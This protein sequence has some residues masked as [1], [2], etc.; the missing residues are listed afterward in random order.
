MKFSGV[1]IQ[2][3]AKVGVE[4]VRRCRRQRVESILNHRTL[5]V[6][7]EKILSKDSCGA[8]EANVSE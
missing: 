6:G 3:Y 5:D 7:L 4:E 1:V 2:I 8:E